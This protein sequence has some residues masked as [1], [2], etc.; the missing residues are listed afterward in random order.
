MVQESYR[1][2]SESKACRSLNMNPAQ[3][4]LSKSWLSLVNRGHR[5]PDK[6]IDLVDEACAIDK[7]SKAR[8]VE[9]FRFL[10][11]WMI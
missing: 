11:S 10:R 6:E 9:D 3:I 2:S 4:Q 7:A 1:E 5:Q 8:L